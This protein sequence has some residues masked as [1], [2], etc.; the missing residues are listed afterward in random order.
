MTKPHCPT[1]GKPYSTTLGVELM[2]WFSENSDETLRAEDIAVK[3]GRDLTT[4]YK[5]TAKLVRQDKLR[6]KRSQKFK[7]FGL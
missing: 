3:F 2:N 6:C 4:V 5:V 7:E 1:C